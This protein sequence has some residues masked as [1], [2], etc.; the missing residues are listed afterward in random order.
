M[1]EKEY[2]EL[3]VPSCGVIYHYHLG[4]TKCHQWE[5]S[6]FSLYPPKPSVEEML[7]SYLLNK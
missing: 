1:I 2:K 7:E 5:L 6:M 4:V 3:G